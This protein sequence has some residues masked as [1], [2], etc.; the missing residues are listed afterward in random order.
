LTSTSTTHQEWLQAPVISRQHPIEPYMQRTRH[1]LGLADLRFIS[2]MEL[3]NLAA[4]LHWQE[5]GTRVV[6]RLLDLQGNRAWWGIT[7]DE[8]WLRASNGA[9]TVFDS[10]PAADRFLRLLKIERFTVG[11]HCQHA[12]FVAG[13]AQEVYTL[14]DRCSTCDHARCSGGI[15]QDI[16]QCLQ[17][18]ERRLLLNRAT[19]QD[20]QQ[21]SLQSAPAPL[22][23]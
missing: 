13:D 8:R 18:T 10:L 4:K 12:L 1:P 7:L 9:V 2:W 23:T 15:Q 3:A 11:E 20:R 21:V 6:V 16:F 14:G 19:R 17:L 5:L 22:L